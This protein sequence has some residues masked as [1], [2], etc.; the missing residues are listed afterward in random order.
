M[1]ENKQTKKPH[2]IKKLRKKKRV[3]ELIAHES[4]QQE[5]KKTYSIR[6]IKRSQIASILYQTILCLEKHT[7]IEFA[8]PDIQAGNSN[9]FFK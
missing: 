3:K 6:N 9:C 8:F 5:N 7:V 1:E 2:I 4:F